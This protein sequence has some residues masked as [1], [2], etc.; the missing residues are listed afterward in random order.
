MDWGENRFT[1]VA[2]IAFSA[3]GRSSFQSVFDQFVEVFAD[4][5]DVHW[6]VRRSPDFTGFI[7]DL[8]HLIDQ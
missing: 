2:M 4:R 8:M 6:L 3:A 7:D 1:V 5:T